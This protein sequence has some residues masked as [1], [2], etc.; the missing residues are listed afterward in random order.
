[1]EE[2]CE[3]SASVYSMYYAGCLILKHNQLPIWSRYQRQYVLGQTGGWGQACY[4]LVPAATGMLQLLISNPS[5][6]CVKR[7]CSARFKIDPHGSTRGVMS[8]AHCQVRLQYRKWP[9]PR[10]EGSLSA[11]VNTACLDTNF[12]NHPVFTFQLLPFSCN[13]PP[14]WLPAAQTHEWEH[15]VILVFRQMCRTV[16][17]SVQYFSGSYP[18]WQRGIQLWVHR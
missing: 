6:F 4:G 13:P 9:K 5:L 17:S 8:M 11:F 3:R 12:H 1:M 10:M 7:D 18:V 2:K 16:P 15:L 14:R